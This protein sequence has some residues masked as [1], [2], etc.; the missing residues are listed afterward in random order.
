[1][2][3]HLIHNQAYPE[4][5]FFKFPFTVL[6]SCLIIIVFI[7]GCYLNSRADI[8]QINTT[9][10]NGNVAVDDSGFSLDLAFQRWINGGISGDGMTGARNESYVEALGEDVTLDEISI[11]FVMTDIQTNSWGDPFIE[12]QDPNLVFRQIT[13]RLR[14]GDTTES[15]KIDAV[16]NFFDSAR[17]DSVSFGIP[18]GEYFSISTTGVQRVNH[19]GDLQN[20]YRARVE[21]GRFTETFGFRFTCEE[22][23]S[24]GMSFAFIYDS[25]INS[26]IYNQD[27]VLYSTLEN[28]PDDQLVIHVLGNLLTTS[29]S[30]LNEASATAANKYT[31][32]FFLES[33]PTE[34]EAIEANEIT[35]LPTGNFQ[36]KFPGLIDDGTNS[37][38]RL[39]VYDT[40]LAANSAAS[41]IYTEIFPATKVIDFQGEDIIIGTGYVAREIC[42]TL[43][44][45]H[46]DL[47][48]HDSPIIIM[49]KY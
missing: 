30:H 47:M 18:L 8:V 11:L 48:G 40:L 20:I 34:L 16:S 28:G 23:S 10:T 2:T 12:A 22:N 38:Y 42:V 26:R 41:P 4:F 1:M 43:N 3:L 19:L 24:L 5:K 49:R 45:N 44:P 39:E 33:L 36:V 14:F 35:I 7:G 37:Y 17:T 46:P 27:S 29:S 31:V 9:D 15:L 21:V 25:A 6:K 13:L 32:D